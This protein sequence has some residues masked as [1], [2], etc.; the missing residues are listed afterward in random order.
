MRRR[1]N[2][3]FL[4]LVESCS[5]KIAHFQLVHPNDVLKVITGTS[6]VASD[7]D[8]LPIPI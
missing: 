8:P 5:T 4:R 2:M 1:A 7:L 3:I 6:N